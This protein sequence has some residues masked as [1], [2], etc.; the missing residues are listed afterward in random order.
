MSPYNQYN[1]PTFNNI[2]TIISFFHVKYLNNNVPGQVNLR[3][4]GIQIEQIPTNLQFLIRDTLCP[5]W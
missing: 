2:N 1:S 5:L 4:R 3:H